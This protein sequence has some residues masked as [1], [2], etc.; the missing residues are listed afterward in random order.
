KGHMSSTLDET[1]H[2]FNVELMWPLPG[3]TL[4]SFKDGIDELCSMGAQAF[5]VYPLLWINNIGY[6]EKGDLGVVTLTEDDAA[7]A[8]EIVVQTREV[9]Y[10]DYIQGL[11]FT[12][13][14]FLLHDC[15]G[16]YVTMQLLSQLGVARVRDVA[17]AF[18]TWMESH[19]GDDGLF[20]LWQLGRRQP[21]KLL[22]YIWKGIV[23]DA[24]MH[25]HRAQFDEIVRRFVDEHSA[26]L[27][28]ERVAAAVEF[29]L[30]SRPYPFVQTPLQL[31]VS[32]EHLRVVKERRGVWTVASPYDFPTFVDALRRGETGPIDA[33]GAGA[34]VMLR[35]DHRRGQAFRK[36]RS[37]DDIHW[38]LYRILRGIRKTEARYAAA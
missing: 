10:D 34:E 9:S 32:L 35:I 13:A 36:E 19:P 2:S 12:Q 16:L 26:W 28:D 6:R 4:D 31:G 5:Q 7:G 1:S 15:R 37:T 22:Q 20:G 23:A 24:V 14:V 29:D 33:L 25:E 17:E 8:G 11:L 21:E 3:E 30:M 18:V 38:H 27:A